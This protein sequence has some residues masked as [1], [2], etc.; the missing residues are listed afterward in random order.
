MEQ[1]IYAK[2]EEISRGNKELRG[3]R[4]SEFSKTY[5]RETGVPEDFVRAHA[6]KWII[7]Y[8]SGISKDNVSFIANE[9]DVA[10]S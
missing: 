10:A 7:E 6:Y 8:F 5:S 1:E 3:L 4:V 9:N 2:L